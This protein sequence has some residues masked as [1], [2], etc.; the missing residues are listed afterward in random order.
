MIRLNVSATNRATGNNAEAKSLRI[1]TIAC[2]IGAKAVPITAVRSR[3]AISSCT[4]IPGFTASTNEPI[5]PAKPCTISR[6]ATGAAA[7]AAA[8]AAMPPVA[9][10]TAAP[11]ALAIAP[12][13]A[14]M[15]LA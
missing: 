1:G 11:P 8:P 9:A 4:M 7:N 3:V 2:M 10:P 5:F 15:P 13:A 12:P 6:N 14:F